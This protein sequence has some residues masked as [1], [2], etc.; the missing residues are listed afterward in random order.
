MYGSPGLPMML[1]AAVILEPLKLLLII[2]FR[3]YCPYK[4]ALDTDNK[5]I[6]F[7]LPYKGKEKELSFYDIDKI[8]DEGDQLRFKC[9]NGNI[10]IFDVFRRE[11]NYVM[12]LVNIVGCDFKSMRFNSKMSSTH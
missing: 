3:K 7:Y 12:E 4:V 11:E 5:K 2:V 1:R 9:K 10:F 8:T 6:T